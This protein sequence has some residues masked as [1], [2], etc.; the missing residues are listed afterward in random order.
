MNAFTAL[1]SYAPGGIDI[2]NMI[3]LFM[4]I[5]CRWLVMTS[6]IPFLGAILIPSLIRIGLSCVLS[7]ASLLMILNETVVPH[8]LSIFNVMALFFKEVL[9]GFIIG[10]LASLIFYAYELMGELLDFS[11]AASMARL[12]LPHVRYQ[13]SP[14]G[15]LLFQLSLT[16]FFCLGLHRPVL[17]SLYMSFEKFPPFSLNTGLSYD[18]SLTIAISVLATLFELAIKLSLPVIFVCFL[19]DIA[20]GLMNRVAPQIN[21]Y[22]LSLPAKMLSGLLIVLFLLPLVIDEFIDHAKELN[23][24]LKALVF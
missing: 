18:P 4:L 5:F 15:T 6:V 7:L 24:F 12:L 14:M 8:S 10:F 23:S 13:S 1:L 3:L 19:I 2:A 11:R 16:T 9:L 17:E 21:A 22:F 20:F